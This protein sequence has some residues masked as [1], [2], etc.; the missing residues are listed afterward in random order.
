M[1]K[2][3]LISFIKNPI[4]KYTDNLPIYISG[5]SDNFFLI[6]LF[7]LR[8][9]RTSSKYVHNNFTSY[10]NILYI[11]FSKK[12]PFF[13][14]SKRFFTLEVKAFNKLLRFLQ[15]NY[16]P[17]IAISLDSKILRK[18]LFFF[19]ENN[20]FLLTPGNSYTQ[21]S[22]THY[23]IYLDLNNEV[24]VYIYYSFIKF[25]FFKVNSLNFKKNLYFYLNRVFFFKKYTVL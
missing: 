6:R 5:I 25:F 8:D 20:Y 24:N 12:F 18:E 14:F 15:K 2:F 19:S 22:N 17:I 7:N 16:S 23:P 1:F 3:L 4:Y 11:I 9:K 10:I 21:Y 13:I